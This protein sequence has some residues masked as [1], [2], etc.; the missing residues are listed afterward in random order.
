MNWK[1]GVASFAMALTE[2]LGAIGKQKQLS[3]TAVDNT[4][5]STA[6]VHLSSVIESEI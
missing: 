5:R 1:I 6:N 2:K 4:H 3:V